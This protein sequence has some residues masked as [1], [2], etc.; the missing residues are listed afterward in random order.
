[1]NIRRT[2]IA[3]ALFAGASLLGACSKAAA[4]ETAGPVVLENGLTAKEQIETR[5]AQLKKMGK[6][7]KAMND[8]MKAETPD[9]A[10]LQAAAA[11]LKLESGGIEDWFPAGT[12][13]DSGVKTE[14]LAAIWENPADF[15]E[16]LSDFRAASDSLA[17][18]APGG[19]LAA[20]G[21]AMRVTGM[22][23]K[24]CHDTYREDD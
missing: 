8:E 3:I 11:A 13:P 22:S 15:A 5:Q 9:V 7:F 19:D 10:A 20:I 6:A 1:M 21:D 12:G 17:E 18:V 2:S 4:P 16:K 24:S 23:C 14:A